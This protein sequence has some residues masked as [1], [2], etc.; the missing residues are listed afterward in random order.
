MFDKIKN[1]LGGRVQPSP[2]RP[3]AAEPVALPAVDPFAG[4]TT[5]TAPPGIRPPDLV[6]GSIDHG[7]HFRALARND[8]EAARLCIEALSASRSKKTVM[9]GKDEVS[10]YL[11]GDSPLQVLT[12]TKNGEVLAAYPVFKAGSPWT[13]RITQITER[14]SGYE[15]QLEV[16]ASGGTLTFFDALYFRN[17][18]TY[19]PGRDARVLVAG[20]AYVMARGRGGAH[21]DDLL[22]RYEGGDVDDCVFRG[23]AQAVA[24]FSVVGRKARAIKTAV[25]P[26]HEG[27]PL[28]LW[29]CVTSNAMQEKIAPG[30]RISGIVWL[31]GFVLP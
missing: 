18:N 17:K 26:G 19:A 14:Q 13:A 6:K 9:Y 12:A 10:G 20:I 7:G 29:I 30:D 21:E 5:E 24:E 4:A 15:G 23:T 1:A 16:F 2:A 31:Q 22:V 27:K 3:P 8:E 11:W 28:D 25:R